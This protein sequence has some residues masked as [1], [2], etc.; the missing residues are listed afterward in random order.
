MAKA[1]GDDASIA[2]E[3]AERES[4]VTSAIASKNMAEAVKTALQ[5]PP[6]TKDLELK[7]GV[8]NHHTPHPPVNIHTLPTTPHPIARS[9]TL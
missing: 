7:V 2:A 3:I 1:A 5:S 9:A 8:A 4:A 6:H